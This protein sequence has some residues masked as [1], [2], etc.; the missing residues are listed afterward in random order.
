MKLDYLKML[1]EICKLTET[2]FCM[3]MELRQLGGK[4]TQREAERMSDILGKVY[5][6]SHCWHCTA[7]QL[8]YKKDA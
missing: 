5:S 1:K 7:C 4:Y 8:K 6:I 2:D 3:D